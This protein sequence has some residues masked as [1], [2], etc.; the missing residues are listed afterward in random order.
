MP[1]GVL[2][3]GYKSW[4]FSPTGNLTFPDGTTNS[5]DTVISTSTYNIQS[6]GNTLIQTSANAGAK[7]WTFGTN[8]SLTFPDTTVQ[9]TAWA[10]GRVVAVPTAS[11]GAAGDKQGDLAFNNS[12]IYYCTQNFTPSS[13]S[14]TIVLTY[15]GT[16]P[17]IVKG[18]IP[19]PQAGWELIHDGNTYILDAN[20]TEGNPGEWS[21]SLSSSISVTIGD[22][23]TIGPASVPNIWKRVAWSGDTW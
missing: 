10:G 11:I 9:T 5:G 16:Y 8:G 14:S 1:V 12:Y 19:Q 15:S 7:T 22:S 20:A 21:L 17:T 4:V 23:V 3:N 13:Y 18:S 6:I 2:S